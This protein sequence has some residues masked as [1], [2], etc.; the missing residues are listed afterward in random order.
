MILKIYKSKK[1]K[2][3]W[4]TRLVFREIG[5]FLKEFHCFGRNFFFLYLVYFLIWYILLLFCRYFIDGS[6]SIVICFSTSKKSQKIE[7]KQALPSKNS[8]N[9]K[10]HNF[11]KQP[12]NSEIQNF[13]EVFDHGLSYY[14]IKSPKFGFHFPLT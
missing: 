14:N 3:N 12:R 7:F 4:R 2:I 13:L 11:G 10:F 1:L 6:E 9:S 8:K 5:Y